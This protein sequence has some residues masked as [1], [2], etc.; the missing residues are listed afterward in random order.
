MMGE[1][2]IPP[3]GEARP[4]EVVFAA[5]RE[6]LGFTD[7]YPTGA[8]LLRHALGA[9]EGPLAVA[10]A[11]ARLRELRERRRIGFDFPGERPIQFVTAFPRTDDRKAHLWAEELGPDPYAVLG[12]LDDDGGSTRGG[13]FPLALISPASDKTISSSLAEYGFKEAILEMHP[14]DAAA[15]DLADGA[16]VRMHNALGEVVVRL[17]LSADMRPGVVSLPKGIWNRHTKNG[18]VG[19]ALVPDALSPVAGGACFNDARVE[20]ARA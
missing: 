9:I 2:V 18:A 16:T 1:P 17:R 12:E 7:S 20:V 8:A 5:L 4:N 11:D 15:R 13:A 3:V 10:G 6:R 14:E 19:N